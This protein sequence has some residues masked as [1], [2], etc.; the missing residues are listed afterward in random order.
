MSVPYSPNVDRQSNPIVNQGAVIA[1]AAIDIGAKITVQLENKDG[2]SLYR[3]ADDEDVWTVTPTDLLFSAPG[4]SGSGA[5]TQLSVLPALNGFGADASRVF[6]NDPEF[7]RA[8]VKNQIQYIGAAYQWQGSDRASASRGISVQMAGFKTLPLGA[9]EGDNYIKPGDLVCAEV[10]LPHRQFTHRRGDSA[11]SVIARG[12]PPNKTTLQMRRCSPHSA[13]E[14]LIMHINRILRDP[15][16]WKHAMGERLLGTSAWATAAHSVMTSYLAGGLLMVQRLM[17]LN[18]IGTSQ[19]FRDLPETKEIDDEW[20][21]ANTLDEKKR[22]AERVTAYLAKLLG[23]V[24]DR[25][26]IRGRVVDK[27][28]ECLREDI[29]LRIFYNGEYPA[30]EFGRGNSAADGNLEKRGRHGDNSVN[31]KTDHGKMLDVQLNHV[32]RAVSGFHAAILDDLRFI[33][34]KAAT[35]ASYQGSGNAH[36]ML[37]IAR[38]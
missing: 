3:G 5:N 15:Q 18:L 1:G 38:Q 37:G 17:E 11:H 13:S 20:R 6:P 16:R 25:G 36:V 28:L 23:V 19:G 27:D 4:K 9:G 35:G 33:I 22:A 29:L 7:V 24:D 2:M 12:A 26:A 31:L 14:A 32:R 21:K 30:Y 34:G 8:C 10:P